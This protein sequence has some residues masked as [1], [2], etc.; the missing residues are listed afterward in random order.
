MLVAVGSGVDVFAGVLVR[1]D[2]TEVL[3]GVLVGVKVGATVA[4]DVAVGT[5]VHV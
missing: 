3:V 1:V 4:V 5:G 2:G